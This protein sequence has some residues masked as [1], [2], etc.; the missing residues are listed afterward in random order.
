[1][2]ITSR[3]R[4]MNAFD[5]CTSSM[6]ACIS[7]PSIIRYYFKYLPFRF[8][9]KV[10]N[11]FNCSYYAILFDLIPWKMNRLL[12]TVLFKKNNEQMTSTVLNV[13]FL[14]HLTPKLLWCRLSL[15]LLQFTRSLYQWQWCD[16]ENVNLHFVTAENTF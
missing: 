8:I 2:A 7:K 1:M 11:A 12:I 15:F 3:I 6:I 13:V 10:F 16:I 9:R 5:I 14:M 4:Q